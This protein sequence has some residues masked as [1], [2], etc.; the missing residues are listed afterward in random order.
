MKEYVCTDPLSARMIIN[1]LGRGIRVTRE[2]GFTARIT[3]CQTRRK[4]AIMRAATAC[5]EV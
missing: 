2:E 5:R 4:A 1:V 3:D